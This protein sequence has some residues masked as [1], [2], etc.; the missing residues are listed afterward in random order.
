MR[1]SRSSKLAGAARGTGEAAEIASRS[2]PVAPR[3]A[4]EFRM[5]ARLPMRL[6]CFM[7]QLLFS[8]LI[9][10]RQAE[11]IVLGLRHTEGLRNRKLAASGLV[12]P[13]RPCH[14]SKQVMGSPV[15]AIS[16]EGRVNVQQ[17]L[18][19]Q[20][21]LILCTRQLIERVAVPGVLASGSFEAADGI[22]KSGLLAEQGS[23]NEVGSEFVGVF[24]QLGSEF[25]LGLREIA[26]PGLNG[27]EK[28]MDLRPVRIKSVNRSEFL[29]CL[30]ILVQAEVG[31]P[32]E[33]M[34]SR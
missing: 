15:F 8:P 26:Q 17:G 25:P 9:E 22:I 34:D 3:V 2:N 18:F 6:F 20:A 21:L 11:N 5:N 27:P 24:S 10:L 14:L 28:K 23:E 29:E 33:E 12:V 7:R 31:F 4:A 19:T 32:Q 13:T 30:W 1:R 16:L